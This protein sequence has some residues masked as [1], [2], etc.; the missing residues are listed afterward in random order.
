MIVAN[1]NLQLE[2]LTD[3][4]VRIDVI[5]GDITTADF[6]RVPETVPLGEKAA[7]EMAAKLAPL[8]VP[9]AEYHAWRASVTAGQN[10]ETRLADVQ[11]KG[12]ERVNP[13]YLK[14]RAQVKPGDTVDTAK[15]SAEAQR[16]SALQE[17]ESVEYRLTGDPDNPTLEWWPQG[18]ALGTELPQVRPG[19]VRLGRRRPGVRGLRQAHAH[20]A[21]LAGRGMAQPGAARL[22]QQPVDQLLPATRRR[23]AVLR[24][25]QGCSGLARGKTS[26]STT[27]AWP[28]TSSATGAAISTSASISAT[29]RRFAPVTCTRDV[30]RP[31]R[32][33]RRFCRRTTR[34]DA[35]LTMAA[36][37]DSRD[38]P[39]TR[40]AVSRP[41]WSMRTSTIRWARTSIG[42]ASNW[43]SAWPSRCA[44]TSSG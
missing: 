12:M 21:E 17:F 13:E 8:A 42:N 28:A 7:R 15:I 18:K 33:V 39:S 38:T 30:R 36:T 2:T 22:F 40:H 31:S 23:A 44:A 11:Y 14:Q 5:M 9:E 37:Y 20:L 4:D 10:I 3:R 26:S 27:N 24:R 43:A 29:T 35:G 1:E 25:T 6:E 41:R 16:M 34:D 32:R 19:A